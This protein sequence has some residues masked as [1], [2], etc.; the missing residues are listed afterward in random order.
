M[1]ET[2]MV[3]RIHGV[4]LDEEGP[5]K[6]EF[7]SVYDAELPVT[8]SPS[9]FRWD[10]DDMETLFCGEYDI[11]SSVI[12][13]EQ[14]RVVPFDPTSSVPFLEM[15][16]VI[17]QMA[18]LTYKYANLHEPFMKALNDAVVSAYATIKALTTPLIETAKEKD[19]DDAEWVS[20]NVSGL[21]DTTYVK[22]HGW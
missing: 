10:G 18:N 1:W 17:T 6:L 3:D 22:R 19:L 13:K 4:D 20:S 11:E 8:V 21:N 15:K 5:I 12:E 14:K 9:G 16:A 2:Y 7:T